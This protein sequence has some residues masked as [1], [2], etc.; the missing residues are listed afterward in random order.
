M[1]GILTN[2]QTLT[3]NQLLKITNIK[4]VTHIDNEYMHL[5]ELTESA[6]EI[7]QGTFTPTDNNTLTIN[8]PL[9]LSELHSISIITPATIQGVAPTRTVSTIVL[10][11]SLSF[12]E[13]ANAQSTTRGAYVKA[14]NALP[15][16]S[17]TYYSWEYS[18]GVFTFTITTPNANVSGVFNAL[19]YY[20]Y[21]I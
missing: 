8:I 13:W 1:K 15:S 2:S 12:I 11:P 14:Q 16:G 3:N 18:N 6:I 4:G 20:Y 17:D 19:E 7:S 10:T 21:A 5:C 9:N